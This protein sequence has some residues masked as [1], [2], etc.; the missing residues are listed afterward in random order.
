MAIQDTSWIYRV[1]EK[2]VCCLFWTNAPTISSLPQEIASLQSFLC[3]RSQERGGA[4]CEYLR[5]LLSYS[6]YRTIEGILR[7]SRV[8]RVSAELLADQIVRLELLAKLS[9]RYET[10]Q[11]VRK[12]YIGY[13]S[14]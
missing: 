9:A 1:S 3:H 13:H 4:H 2:L 14:P 8:A 12:R 5:Y 7:I 10:V 11:S 6:R